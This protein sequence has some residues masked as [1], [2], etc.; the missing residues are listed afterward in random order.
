M[1]LLEAT[2]ADIPK[3]ERGVQHDLRYEKEESKPLSIFFAQFYTAELSLTK[4]NLVP[5]G[6]NTATIK[7]FIPGSND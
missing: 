6:D 7:P 5:I 4:N 1:S 2:I 3:K